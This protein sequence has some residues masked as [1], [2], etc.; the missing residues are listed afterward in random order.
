M[1]DKGFSGVFKEEFE[2]YLEFKHAQGFYLKDE[3]KYIYLLLQINRFL[4]TFD[5]DEIKI[6]KEMAE[7]TVDLY[8]DIGP[9]TRHIYECAFRQ[10]SKF[11]KLRGYKEIYIQ[12]N[13]IEK[14]PRDYIPYVF[15]NEEIRKI[16]NVI[17]NWKFKIKDHQLN[18]LYKT[19]FRVLY[20]TGIRLGELVNLKI[21]DV[22][23]I[24][25]V[26]TVNNGKND[27]TRIL[28][29]KESLA[30]YLRE[31]LK[32]FPNNKEYFF[33]SVFRPGNKMI[34][35]TISDRFGKH[36]L[37]AVGI[38]KQDTVINY[39][40]GACVHSLRHTFACN[41]LDQMIKEG[42]DPYCAL[43]YLSVYMGHTSIT[44]TEIYLRLTEERYNEVIDCGHYIYEGLGDDDE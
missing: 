9:A 18:I 22:D 35:H 30:F 10:F 41:A 4:N 27:V 23:L 39:S 16:F 13:S 32:V 25:N 19:I 14:A 2:N 1:L 31:Y 15:S 26:I 21:N 3:D 12:Y 24:N 43:P 36:I 40:R 8:K 34:K 33:E 6:T 17:D 20:C 38:N 11:L 29:F 5:L 37:P 44:N 42:K 7:N 28:P